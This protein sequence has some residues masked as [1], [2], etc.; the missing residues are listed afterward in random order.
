MRDLCAERVS[1]L[2]HR[3][4]RIVLRCCHYLTAPNK[5]AR[6]THNNRGSALKSCATSHRLVIQRLNNPSQSF[7]D[8]TAKQ[9]AMLEMLASPAGVVTGHSE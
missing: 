8:V 6:P 7:S 4:R 9:T 5:S 2:L 3:L 1:I